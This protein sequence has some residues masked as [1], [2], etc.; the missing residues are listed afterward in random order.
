MLFG[1]GGFG[2]LRAFTE[3]TEHYL[4]EQFDSNI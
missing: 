3:F 1:F 2:S 4:F